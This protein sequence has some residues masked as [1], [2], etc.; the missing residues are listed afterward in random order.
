MSPRDPAVAIT[1]CSVTPEGNGEHSSPGEPATT[2]AAAELASDPTE[3]YTA[4][5]AVTSSLPGQPLSQPKSPRWWERQRVL[6]VVAGLV[7]VALAAT[8]IRNRHSW[9]W[10]DVPTWILAV[11]A[12]VTTVYAIRAFRLQADE[13]SKL[14][15]DRKD[16]QALNRQQIDVLQL[17]AQELRAAIQQ[18]ERAA[19]ESTASVPEPSDAQARRVYATQEHLDRNPAIPQTQ[20]AT[21]G[22][23]RPYVRVTVA[24][25]SDDAIRELEFDWHAGSALNGQP[26]FIGQVLP[27][28]EVVRGRDVPVG[29]DPARFTVAVRFRTENGR[30]WLRRADDGSLY[31]WPPSQSSDEAARSVSDTKTGT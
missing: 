19:S 28:R 26:D 4:A 20:V 1:L 10:G 27:G 7:V 13:V 15:Q 16:Q 2:E 12:I 17:Q 14:A 22:K 30:T 24:N 9:N 21:K 23:P 8:G 11:G 18:R 6:V 31:L 29:I 5:S 3:Y 25:L